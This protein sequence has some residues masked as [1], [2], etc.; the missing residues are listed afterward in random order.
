M[1]P[2]VWEFDTAQRQE[3][4]Q[5]RKDRWQKQNATRWQQHN[6]T[7]LREVN[8]VMQECTNRDGTHVPS[9]WINDESARH[10]TAQEVYTWLKYSRYTGANMLMN[11]GPRADGSIHPD[12]VKALGQVGKLIKQ[13]GWPPV[14]HGVPPFLAL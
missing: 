11:I 8:T 2:F 10:L 13:K 6:Q 5:I 1:L 7:L 14:V 3:R 12:D 4:Y 9:G